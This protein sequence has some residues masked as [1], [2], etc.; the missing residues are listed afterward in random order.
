MECAWEL[1]THLMATFYLRYYWGSTK[2]VK[3][4]T[5]TIFC[6]TKI[7]KVSMEPTWL[8]LLVCQIIHHCV[9]KLGMG[10][11]VTH[12]WFRS[13]EIFNNFSATILYCQAKRSLVSN[14]S[15]IWTGEGQRS[16]SSINSIDHYH[17]WTVRTEYRMTTLFYYHVPT[18]YCITV[19][20][21]IQLQVHWLFQYMH[22]EP[23]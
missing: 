12:T 2:H 19:A 18:V 1:D 13:G 14:I 11:L 20:M 17:A 3:N 5:T 22:I 16:C 6:P 23:H 21:T 7:L 4:C 15:Q 9:W 10:F 8:A